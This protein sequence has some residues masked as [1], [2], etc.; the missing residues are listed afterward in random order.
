MPLNNALTLCLLTAIVGFLISSC[1]TVPAKEPLKI[2]AHRVVVLHVESL[3][4]ELKKA[5]EPAYQQLIKNIEKKG[6]YVV[7]LTAADNQLLRDK[8]MELS[9]SVYDPQVGEFVPL[10]RFT[11]IKAMID[12]SAK[13]FSHDVVLMPE[14]VLRTTNVVGD[15]MQWDGV[16]REISFINQP[17]AAYDLPQRGKGLSLRLAGYTRNGAKVF[18]DFS[19]ISLPYHLRYVNGKLTLQ[20][21]EQF[22]TDKELK[23]GVDMALNPFFKQVT[24]K[25]AK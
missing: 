5:A 2:N 13:L 16:K 17:A 12:L 24:H 18:L 22:F 6:F 19:G 8:A 9:G 4:K 11:Y 15:E 10:D 25:N 21:K 1:E 3:H 23:D 20:L 14:V 7:P